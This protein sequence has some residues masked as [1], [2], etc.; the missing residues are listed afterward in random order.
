M[1]RATGTALE[2]LSK[3][4][5]VVVANHQNERISQ[6]KNIYDAMTMLGEKFT[7]M[8]QVVAQDRTKLVKCGEW[9]RE[10]EA[11]LKGMDAAGASLEHAVAGIKGEV[12]QISTQ[13]QELHHNM[14]STEDRLAEVLDRKFLDWAKNYSPPPQ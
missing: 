7:A 5:A 3:N 14:A 11:K 12:A 1:Y 13:V 8:H 6:V 4:I 10:V 2:C 9:S